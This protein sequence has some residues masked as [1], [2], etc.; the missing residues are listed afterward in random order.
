ML[1]EGGVLKADNT[2]YA[3][4]DIIALANTGR[5]YLFSSLKFT[6]A[7]QEVEPV[8]YPGHGTSLLGLATY[9]SDYHGGCGLAQG[10]YPDITTAAALANTGFAI[11]SMIRAPDPNGSFQYAIPMRHIFGFVN[12]YSKVT[13][14]MR[15]TLQLIRKDDNDALYRAAAAGAGKVKLS[16]MAW[17]VPIVQPNDVRNA[18]LYKSIASNNCRIV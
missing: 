17:F 6:V 8:N 5:L 18:N 12:D 11:Q 7:G 15:D 9:S 16:K 2:R 3:D 10:W 4:A 1:I 13:Y 14:G